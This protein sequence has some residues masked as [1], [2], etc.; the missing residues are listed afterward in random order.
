MSNQWDRP[1]L[2]VH[3]LHTGF[4]LRRVAWRPGHDTELA[5]VPLA[6]QSSSSSPMDGA[7]GT[8]PSRAENESH[9]IDDDAHIEIW[10][11][12]RHYIAKYAMA[13]GEGTAIAI[14]WSDEDTFVSAFQNGGFVQIG[15]K[16]QKALPLDNIPR[17]VMAWNS[18]GELAY[19]LDQFKLGEI[20]F[21]DV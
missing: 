6:P 13:S 21:D 12:R 1:P 7:T 8:K 5:I 4:P 14:E 10:D 9:S 17:Q 19:A 16:S 15:I 3:T 18:R 20:P 2:P 11:V